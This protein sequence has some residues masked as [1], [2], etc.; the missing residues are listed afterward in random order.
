MAAPPMADPA[1]DVLE[2]RVVVDGVVRN[3]VEVVEREA[4]QRALHTEA[5]QNH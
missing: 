4:A 5:G 2:G 3:E 1:R